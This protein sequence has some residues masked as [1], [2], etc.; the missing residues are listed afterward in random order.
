MYECTLATATFLPNVL[1]RGVNLHTLLVDDGTASIGLRIPK[2][3]DVRNFIETFQDE[4]G[5]V[6]LVTRREVDQPVM[7]ADEFKNTVRERL[8]ARQEEVVQTAYFSG[9]FEWPRESTGGEVADILGVTQP[10]VNRHIRA[11]ERTLFGLVYEDYD[12]DVQ[13][14]VDTG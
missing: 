13:E 4:F 14:S 10:T 8:T 7:S 2:T 11:G 1:E 9:F 6:E 12:A 3:A 5:T